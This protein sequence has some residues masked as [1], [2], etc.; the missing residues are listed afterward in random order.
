MIRNSWFLQLAVISP[1]VFLLVACGGSQADS[2][3]PFE[4]NEEV[5][6]EDEKP[7]DMPKDETAEQAKKYCDNE[8]EKS[9]TQP[10]DS[11]NRKQIQACLTSIRPILNAKCAKGVEKEIV[12]KVIIEKTGSVSGAFAVGDSA[13]CPEAAC[14]S[15][16]VTKVVFPKFKAKQQQVIEKY[17]FKLG[18]VDK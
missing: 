11:L 12:L 13:D 16:Q 10:P 6:S 7:R 15:E 5:S 3:A 17:P 4:G 2:Q 14:V 1:C 9:D 18:P 8:V